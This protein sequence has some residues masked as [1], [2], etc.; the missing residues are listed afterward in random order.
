MIRRER[1]KPDCSNYLREMRGK[2]EERMELKGVNICGEVASRGL[3]M[4][5]LSELCLF[6]GDIYL[7]FILYSSFYHGQI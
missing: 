4:S 6:Y 5:M 2:R 1:V 7:I 3:L